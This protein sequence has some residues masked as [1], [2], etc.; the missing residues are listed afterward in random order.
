[1]NINAVGKMKTIIFYN[2][3][4]MALIVTSVIGQVYLF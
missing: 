2:N 1:M 3:L 4:C